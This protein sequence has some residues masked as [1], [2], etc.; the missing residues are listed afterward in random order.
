MYTKKQIKINYKNFQRETIFKIED[1][2]KDNF[3]SFFYF[4]NDVTESKRIL[5]K[6]F[7]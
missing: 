2:E 1:E 3:I 6:R 4:Y 5:K 7:I